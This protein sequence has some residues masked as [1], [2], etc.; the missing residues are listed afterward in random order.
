MFIPDLNFSNPN[1]GSRV[2][3]TPYPGSGSTSKNLSIF[4]IKTVSKLPE[5]WSGIFIPDSGSGIFSIP[6]PRVKKALD[7]GSAT[8]LLTNSW[9]RPVPCPWLPCDC[10]ALLSLSPHAPASPRLGLFYSLLYILKAERIMRR[11]M[12]GWLALRPALWGPLSWRRWS[13]PSHRRRAPV[14]RR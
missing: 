6:D 3:K 2:K 4:S 11:L 7:P 13:G 12:R 5:K 14:H 10:P 8:L 9:L 1:P